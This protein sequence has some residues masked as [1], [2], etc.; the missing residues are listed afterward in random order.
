MHCTPT[1]N[2]LTLQPDFLPTDWYGYGGQVSIAILYS[3]YM[4]ES[5]D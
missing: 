2:R 5:H 3:G 1:W 4:K